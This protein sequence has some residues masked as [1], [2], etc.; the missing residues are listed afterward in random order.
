MTMDFNVFNT[1]RIRLVNPNIKHIDFLTKLTGVQPSHCE[2]APDITIIYKDKFPINNITLIG[3]D[4]GFDEANFYVLVKNVDTSKAIIPFDK[5]GEKCEIICEADFVN[6]PLLHE[7]ILFS[8][9]KKI[10]LRY[11]PLLL[12][13]ME[14]ARSY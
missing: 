12:F 1:T 3:L 4:A 14:K 7:I 10:E 11:I 9:P 8:F 6:I 2:E 5:I 13:L